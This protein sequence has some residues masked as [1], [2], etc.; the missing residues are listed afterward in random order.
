M[1]SVRCGACSWEPLS[2]WQLFHTRQPPVLHHVF[3][4]PYK[5]ALSPI[6]EKP[7]SAQ[8]LCPFS[9]SLNSIK[10]STILAAPPSSYSRSHQNLT[11]AP[12]LPHCCPRPASPPDSSLSSSKSQCDPSAFLILSPCT[13][14]VSRFSGPCHRNV[15]FLCVPQLQSQPPHHLWPGPSRLVSLPQSWPSDP[16]ITPCSVKHLQ[17]LSV[18]PGTMSKFLSV[19]MGTYWWPQISSQPARPSIRELDTLSSTP[20]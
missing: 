19:P 2:K 7:Y 1:F 16:Y 5:Y 18:I 10:D 15:T 12:S 3:P 6:L 17:G 14:Q 11:P 9:S 13:Q 8:S 20:C 4:S